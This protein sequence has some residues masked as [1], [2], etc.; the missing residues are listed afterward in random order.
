MLTGVIINK[1]VWNEGIN[2]PYLA[3]GE[4]ESL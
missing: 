4:A 3:E 1:Y 2:D